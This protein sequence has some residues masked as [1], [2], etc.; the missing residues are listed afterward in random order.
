[1]SKIIKTAIL[2]RVKKMGFVEEIINKGKVLNDTILTRD[3]KANYSQY[4]AFKN[5][6]QTVEKLQRDFEEAVY[7]GGIRSVFVGKRM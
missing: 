7:R 5:Y 6:K 3:L 1:M 4:S 2:K